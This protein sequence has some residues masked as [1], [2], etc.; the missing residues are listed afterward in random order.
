MFALHILQ[1]FA[2]VLGSHRDLFLG[3]EFPAG[4]VNHS[5]DDQTGGGVWGL[6]SARVGG[7][8]GFRGEQGYS[9]LK[10]ECMY[11]QICIV[12]KVLTNNM[13]GRILK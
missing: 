1:Y 5:R 10:Q 8:E 12:G 7:T 3:P 11:C 9:G 13:Y 2:L 4:H 6:L